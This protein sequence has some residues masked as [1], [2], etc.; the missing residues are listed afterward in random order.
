MPRPQTWDH[1]KS[2]KKPPVRTVT[3]PLD[4]EIAAQWQDAHGKLE[5]AKIRLDFKIEDP[6]IHR[7]VVEEIAKQQAILDGLSESMEDSV[8]IFKIK[9]LG[10]KKYENM[11]SD[12]KYQPTEAQIKMNKDRNGAGAVLDWNPDTFP[13]DLIAACMIQPEMT[14]DQV[15]EMWESDEWTQS[16]LLML[17]GAALEVNQQT[18]TVNWGKG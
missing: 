8:A 10:R 6:E 18:R 7:Q 4:D 15:V 1:M 3:I 17:L 5:L 2:R 16:E 11:Q 14:Y 12:T 9:G 13:V